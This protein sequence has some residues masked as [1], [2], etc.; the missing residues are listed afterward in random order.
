[1]IILGSVCL[2]AG[3]VVFGV[4]CAITEKVFGASQALV[5]AFAGV[6]ALTAAFRLVL[7]VSE[8]LGL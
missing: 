7:T 1:M 6:V 2:L 4:L 8:K 3:I 5:L